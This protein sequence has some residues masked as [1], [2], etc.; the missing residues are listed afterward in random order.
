V[1]NQDAFIYVERI[2][3]EVCFKAAVGQRVMD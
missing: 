2:G 1:A 3:I